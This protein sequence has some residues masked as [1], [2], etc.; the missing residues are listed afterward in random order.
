MMSK[1]DEDD[2]EDNSDGDKQN[3]L[4]A[5]RH[6]ML[7]FDIE[8]KKAMLAGDYKLADE[9]EKKYRGLIKAAVNVSGMFK[10]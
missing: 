7:Y 10:K 1:D 8:S 4:D 9:Y 5:I 3:L 2:D 6:S